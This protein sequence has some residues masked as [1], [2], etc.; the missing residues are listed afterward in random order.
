MATERLRLK[1]FPAVH[2]LWHFGLIVL[3][4][5]MGVTG[6]AWMFIETAWGAWMAGWFGGYKGVLEWHRISG[7]IFLAGFV[8]HILYMLTQIDWKRFPGS[9]LGPDTLVYQWTDVKGFFQHLLWIFGLGKAPR[10]DRWSWWEKFDYWAVWWGLIIVGVTGLMLYNPVLSSDYIPGWLL[11]I[12]LWVHRIEAVLAMGHI[13][14]IHFY[15][16][17]FRPTALPFNAAMFDGT[18]SL[19]DA[20]HEHPEWV[21]RLEREGRLQAALVPEPPVV[22]RILYFMGG[23]AIIALGLFLL[24]FSL[25]NVG[26]LTLL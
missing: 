7:L 19:E 4:M 24:I 3:F 25:L 16:E 10:F 23:Y 9:L 1:R 11:N 6:L 18:I 22:M 14:T 15:V 13:F 17:H 21:A 5:T 2:R 12:A 26:A 8:S 20:R